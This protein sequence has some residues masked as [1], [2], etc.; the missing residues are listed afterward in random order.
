[1]ANGNITTSVG[2]IEELPIMINKHIY[3]CNAIVMKNASQKLLIGINWLRTYNVIIDLNECCLYIPESDDTLNYCFL[4]CEQNQGIKNAYT[5]ENNKNKLISNEKSY[6]KPFEEKMINIKFKNKNMLNFD[7]KKL[8]YLESSSIKDLAVAAGVFEDFEDVMKV[9]VVNTTRNTK[10]VEKGQH[11]G[12]LQILNNVDV[13]EI[14]NSTPKPYDR[15]LMNKQ[16]FG[17][18]E[19]INEFITMINDINSEDVNIKKLESEHEINLKTD[20]YKNFNQKPYR[21]TRTEKQI[22]DNQIK[23]LKDKQ[24]IRDSSSQISSPIILVKKKMEV[25]VYV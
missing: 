12:D 23:D 8:F 18:T 4:K 24:L 5:Y 9:C 25:N 17:P 15:E 10:T 19:Y 2:M 11:L 22:I 6:F 14:K 20:E 3:D 21:V 16:Y 7:D 1:M 13:E